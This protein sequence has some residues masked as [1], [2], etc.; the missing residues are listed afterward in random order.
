MKIAVVPEEFS[1][2]VIF[3]RAWD[4][5]RAW[6]PTWLSPI[7]PSISALG[8]RAATESTTTMSIAPERISMSMIS[9]ACSPVSGCETRRASVSTPSLLG[10]LRVQRV[11]GVDER[12]DATGTLRVRDGVQRDRRLAG[13]LRAVDLH[14]AAARESTDPERHV[15]RD[16]A[17]GDHLDGGTPLVA[18]AHDRP[19][20]ELAVDLAEGGLEGLLTVLRCGHGSH[21]VVSSSVRCA[22]GGW[23]S[24]WATV[25][26][27]TDTAVETPHLPSRQ[28]CRTG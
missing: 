3:R 7:S 13:G 11:L 2:P 18:E 19:L 24:S 12:R 23:S 17:G 14:H 25:C 10:V 6:R 1:A 5:R 28:A 20:A 22:C 27:T 4:I 16:R 21:L 9:S 26:P 15:Q 8:T